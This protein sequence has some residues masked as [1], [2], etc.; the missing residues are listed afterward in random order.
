MDTLTFSPGQSI[1]KKDAPV[2]G[3]YLI[4][5]GSVMG[6]S[7]KGDIFLGK[8]DV[9]AVFDLFSGYSFYNY[10]ASDAT[11]IMRYPITDSASLLK[12][13]KSTPELCTILASSA[14]KMCC[15]ILDDS[16][17]QT[18][19]CNQFYQGIVE[20]YRNYVQLCT[21][22]SITAKTITEIEELQPFSSSELLP[23]YLSG[24][25]DALRGLSSEVR[26]ELFRDNPEF[27]YG[28]LQKT[29]DDIHQILEYIRYISAYQADNAYLLLNGSGNDLF[30]LYTSL[31]VALTRRN[32][33]TMSLNALLSKLMIQME[34]QLSIDRNLYQIRIAD[35]MKRIE[36]A[37][38]CAGSDD[39][40][41]DAE[42]AFSSGPLSDSAKIILEYCD[43]PAD[44]V[45]AF[46]DDLNEYKKMSDRSST[47][48]R[49][50]M[51]RK[52][53]TQAFYQMYTPA[54]QYSL[55]DPNPPLPVKLFLL[56]GYIDEG[57]AGIENA[58]DMMDLCDAL[59]DFSNAH[60]YTFYSWLRAVYSGKREPSRN[61]F[62]AD[63]TQHLHEL[64][65][66]GKISTEM[67]H[68]MLRDP[69]GR[70]MYELQN[71][72]PPVNKI[73]SGRVSTFCPFFSEHNCLHKP[74]ESIV[75]VEKLRS[76]LTYITS[77][78]FRAFYRDNLFSMPEAGINHENLQ[79]QVFPDLILMPNTG[80]RGALWQE[81]E[82][83]KRSTPARMMLP[84]LCQEDVT[85]ILTRLTG[86]YRWEMCKRVQGSR[87]NDVSDPSLTSEYFD[88][89]QFYRKNSEL[90][91][92]AKEKIKTGLTRAKNSYKEMFVRDYIQWIYYE[93]SGSPRMNKVVRK[94]YFKYCPFS[95]SIRDKLA[96]NPMY[97]EVLD[98]FNLHNGQAQHRLQLLIH[99]IES[100]G[101]KLPDEILREA[102]F[103]KM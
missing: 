39:E 4:S 86:E 54:F 90:S 43:Y 60:V 22:H 31:C 103:L 30:D 44:Q 47:D 69:A 84:I 15:S 52:K 67:E 13:M 64:K 73:S 42:S 23:D 99:R 85:L 26:N 29:E 96:S 76:A 66:T 25:Y 95:K 34:C 27:T 45:E 9:V 1:L 16:I 59:Y 87:W 40:G 10:T 36:E 48:D 8:G 58:H 7:S 21:K 68:K 5:A 28:Y 57:L 92:D 75:T 80:S 38:L 32:V 82:G 62:D 100:S 50:I 55:K 2:N 70:V 61:E 17:L 20:Y 74:S 35:Y 51:L 78:D 97:K 101:R 94:I 6:S 65:V 102:E 14:T 49:A 18:Y 24:Y 37:Q 3:V 83:R 41:G 79:L 33:D 89:I 93:G 81:I 19:N 71:M 72:F 46:L 12:L 98:Y 56:F 63:Y 53:L 88:Y 91:P 77:I 11:I